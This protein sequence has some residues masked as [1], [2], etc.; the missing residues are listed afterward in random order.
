MVRKRSDQICV[1]CDSCLI[2]FRK[3][4]MLGR[5]RDC[6]SLG[7]FV[8]FFVMFLSLPHF[9][10]ICRLDRKSVEQGKG[11]GPGGRRII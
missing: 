8:V 2:V 6:F 1:K 4:V 9:P 3:V 5:R 10:S 7:F 11:V